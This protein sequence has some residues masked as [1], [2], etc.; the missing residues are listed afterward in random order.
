MFGGW[1]ADVAD[2]AS[3]LLND[4]ISSKISDSSKSTVPIE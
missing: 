3:G 1:L 4:G 2:L